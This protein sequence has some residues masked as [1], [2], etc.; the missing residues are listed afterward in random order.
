MGPVTWHTHHA[1]L[2]RS[3]VFLEDDGVAGL[4]DWGDAV[5]GD[6]HLE[7]IQVYRDVLDCDADLFRAFLEGSAWPKGDDFPRRT[8]AYA[9]RRQALGLAQHLGMDV[10]EPVAEKLAL[11]DVPTLDALAERLFDV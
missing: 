7:L 5:A 2:T 6:R 3:H 4:I 1:D 11:E 9:I 10:F 8:L